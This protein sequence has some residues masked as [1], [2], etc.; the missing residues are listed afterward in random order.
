MNSGAATLKK[1]RYELI[2]DALKSGTFKTKD[3]AEATQVNRN[4]RKNTPDSV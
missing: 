3:M 1:T 4:Q 2:L